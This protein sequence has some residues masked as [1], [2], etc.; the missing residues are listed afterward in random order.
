MTSL[1]LKQFLWL[2]FC[3][4]RPQKQWFCYITMC[5]QAIYF[6]LPSSQQSHW[7]LLLFLVKSC[8]TRLCVVLSQGR[9]EAVWKMRSGPCPCPRVEIIW[10]NPALFSP[11]YIVH[12]D[13]G[14]QGPL[15]FGPINLF[16]WFFFF[17][18][19]LIFNSWYEFNLFHFNYYLYS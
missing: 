15:V 1:L 19:V 12:L 9:E 2:S 16:V 8:S 5:E 6:P 7:E 3:C 10:K 17:F 11:S 13:K 4:F 18:S 14:P